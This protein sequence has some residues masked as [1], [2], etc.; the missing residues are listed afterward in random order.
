MAFVSLG[1]LELVHS[2]NVKS[3]ESIFKVGVFE[4]KYLIGSLL[5]G[6]LLQVI[7]VV[8]PYFANIF[9]LVPLT[10]IQ[11]IYTGL[12]SIVP[13][14]VGEVQKKL[15]EIMG[16]KKLYLNSKNSVNY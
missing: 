9:E 14:V 6:T 3:E 2:F 13:I 10:G 4:N 15:K 11:W 7:V 8:V 12:I 5:L 16:G 1:M